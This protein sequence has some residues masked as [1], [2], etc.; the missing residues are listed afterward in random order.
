VTPSTTLDC[1]EVD[2][3]TYKV[4]VRGERVL[5]SPRAMRV[6]A[7]FV[8]RPERVYTFEELIELAYPDN[9]DATVFWVRATALKPI[10]KALVGTGWKVQNVYGFGYRMER[11]ES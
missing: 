4:H 10:R 1:I 5:M 11:D 6:F 3:A 8:R 7:A 9:Y 2:L